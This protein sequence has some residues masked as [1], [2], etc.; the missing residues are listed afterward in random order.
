MCQTVLKVTRI[1]FKSLQCF[2]FSAITS[3]RISLFINIASNEVNLL[4]CF[5]AEAVTLNCFCEFSAIFIK[6]HHG[7][8][9]CLYLFFLPLLSM[10]CAGK[11]KRRKRIMKLNEN[12]WVDLDICHNSSSNADFSLFY[13]S[14]HFPKLTLF[15]M[16][17][18]TKHP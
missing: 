6:K 12:F 5:Q 4:F 15:L 10:W 7:I 18:F 14:W 3:E 8:Q 17:R 2:K 11:R 13:R 1:C 9:F 16:S